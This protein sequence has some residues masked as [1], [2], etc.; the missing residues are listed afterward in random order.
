MPQTV[1]PVQYSNRIRSANLPV[2]SPS[3]KPST[4]DA[5]PPARV[6]V[7]VQNVGCKLNQYEAEALMS[8]F[9]D[10]G[11]GF[12]S[13]DGQRCV[14]QRLDSFV[15]DVKMHPQIFDCQQAHVLSSAAYILRGSNASRTASP[16]KTKSESITARVQKA[17]K[18]SQGACRL[19]L[20]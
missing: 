17:V 2:I 9:A 11:Y 6:R 4:S 14:A 18:P 20:P 7:A 8:G 12:T 13:F 3:E 10:E 5:S 19:R 1:A 15:L 16:I